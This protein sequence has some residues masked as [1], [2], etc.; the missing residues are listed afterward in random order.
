[1]TRQ[2]ASPAGSGS[3]DAAAFLADPAA[4]RIFTT[5]RSVRSTDVTA[6]GRLRLDAIARYLQEAAEDDVLDAGWDEA[7]DWLLRR[8]VLTMRGYPGRGERVGLRTFCSGLGPRWAERTTTLSDE[9]GDLI[10]AGAIWVAVSR[11]SG[12]TAPLGAE[13]RRLFGPAAQ[14]RKVSARLFH[15]TPDLARSG[16][17][18][19]V[20]ACDFDTA[21][22]VNNTIHWAA[23]EDALVGRDWVPAHA[24]IEYHQPILP[25]CEPRLVTSRSPGQLEVWLMAETGLLASVRLAP[26]A[27]PG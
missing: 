18:W 15:S 11:L 3:A 5:S 14:G 23:A 26:A 1:V 20:R 25:G 8:C 22:H 19:P 16:R 24:E 2:D 27:V 9:N 12:A 6:A 17:P 10:Q 13:F 21:G 7:Q 4:G